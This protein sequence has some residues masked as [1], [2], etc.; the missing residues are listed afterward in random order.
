VPWTKLNARLVGIVI[1]AGGGRFSQV[2]TVPQLNPIAQSLVNRT[3]TVMS[4]AG[5][6]SRAG[7]DCHRERRCCLRG[8]LP[9]HPR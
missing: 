1:G 9:C 7:F 3:G 2:P 5:A 6:A 8:K 4:F